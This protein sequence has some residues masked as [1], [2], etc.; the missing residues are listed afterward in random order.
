M[1]KNF[2]VLADRLKGVKI[3]DKDLTVDLLKEALSKDESFEV[4]AP[5]AHIMT[6]EILTELKTTVKKQGYEEGKTAGS[7]M[8]IKEMKRKAG[9]EFEG[10]TDDQFIQ[11]FTKKIEKEKGIEP[12]KKIQELTES[13]TKL[14]T[15]A[16]QK[17]GEV[18]QWSEKYTGLQRDTMA[19]EIILGKI[20][21]NI[22]GVTPKHFSALFK[23]EG[24]Q[25]AT[26]DSGAVVVMQNGKPLKDKLEKPIPVENVLLDF[27]KTNNWI[28]AEG[29]GAGDEG[30]A[31]NGEF[32]TMNDVF[33]FMETNKIN[34]MSPQGIK[35]Q[36]QFEAETQA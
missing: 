18:K 30:G 15:L 13:L 24:Y 26:D 6:E 5:Q 4:V 16:E 35:L 25:V 14:Q 11:E 17:E 21:K 29:R 7:E 27:A 22:T 2:D 36:E 3:G 10:K 23:M 34:P 31:G 12:N 19:N 32:K 33:K 20:P 8:T 1:I 28:S 9:L